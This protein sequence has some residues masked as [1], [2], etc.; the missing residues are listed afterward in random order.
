[1]ANI[2]SS[3]PSLLNLTLEEKRLFG[4]LFRQAD[5][6]NIGVVTGEAAIKF[7]EKTE[8]DPRILGEVRARPSNIYWDVFKASI[9][10]FD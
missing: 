2:D 7:F 8:L 1:M 6:D 3:A 10:N 4:H 9:D 5:S